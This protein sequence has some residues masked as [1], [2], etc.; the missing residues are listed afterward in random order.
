MLAALATLIEIGTSVII[1]APDA[2]V[3][4]S[5]LL[6]A[7]LDAVPPK[8]EAHFVPPDSMPPPS[9]A[10]PHVTIISGEMSPHHPAYLWGDDL[11]NVIVQ[12]HH[13]AQLLTTT[14]ADDGLGVGRILINTGGSPPTGVHAQLPIV[15]VLRPD[16]QAKFSDHPLSRINAVLRLSVRAGE[17]IQTDLITGDGDRSV[18]MEQIMRAIPAF[19]IERCI[20]W[21]HHITTVPAP[22]RDRERPGVMLDHAENERSRALGGS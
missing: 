21:E 2:G 6:A 22:P 16:R 7:L 17:L 4:K 14:H 5:T 12:V 15:V 20:A 1:A 18:V 3:G 10:S 19:K 8:R 13:G 9:E 11:I